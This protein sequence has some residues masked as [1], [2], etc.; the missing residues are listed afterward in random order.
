MTEPT[1]QPA[2]PTG[3]QPC[4][5]CGAIGAMVSKTKKITRKR[6]VKFGLL[7]LLLCIITVGVGLIVYLVWPRRNETI[8]TDRWVECGNCGLRT[9]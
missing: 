4:P 6:R 1:T 3:Q 5:N 7:W 9:T 8:G 2:P